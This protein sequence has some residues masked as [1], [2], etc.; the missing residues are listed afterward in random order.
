MTA[1]RLQHRLTWQRRIDATDDY[2]STQSDFA[3]QFTEPAE[4]LPARGF[5]QVT[6]AR[7][8][9]QQPVIL[10]VRLNGRTQTIQSD[11]RAVDARN[12]AIVYAVTAPPIDREQTRRWLE[13]PATIG[14]AA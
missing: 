3:N 12:T 14:A 9:G 10:R 11:W 2:G 4:V 5:E 13:I 6:Q 7:L 8:A 1:A